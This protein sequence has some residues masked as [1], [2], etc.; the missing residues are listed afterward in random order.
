MIYGRRARVNNEGFACVHFGPGLTI[1]V[2]FDCT[3]IYKWRETK[4]LISSVFAV[5]SS[6][7]IH[8]NWVAL[9]DAILPENIQTDH[10]SNAGCYEYI[11][12]LE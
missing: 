1:S 7:I 12:V 9:A 11:S 5:S 2:L 4:L 6:E 8:T 10:P 3:E